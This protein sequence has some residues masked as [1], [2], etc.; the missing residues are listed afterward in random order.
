[1][2]SMYS[3]FNFNKL[4]IC[5]KEIVSSNSFFML[6]NYYVMYNSNNFNFVIICKK[7]LILYD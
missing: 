1:M 3:L 2:N 7:I 4:E 6:C 5:Y